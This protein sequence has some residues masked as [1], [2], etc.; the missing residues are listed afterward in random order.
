MLALAA[1]DV[2]VGQDLAGQVVI[3]Y[4]LDHYA[5]E[6][7]TDACPLHFGQVMAVPSHVDAHRQ[8]LPGVGYQRVDVLPECVDQLVSEDASHRV[9]K[10]VGCEIDQHSF[11][12]EGKIK[13]VFDVPS[14][15]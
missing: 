6:D 15:N 12:V 9:Q 1:A 8:T 11:V 13:E 10:A 7:Q 3:V 14:N 2:V 5:A 4:D